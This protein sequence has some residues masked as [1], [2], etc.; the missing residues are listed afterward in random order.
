GRQTLF[1]YAANLIDLLTIQ[2]KTA[3]GNATIGQFTY[4]A[5]HRPLT[6]TD[7]AGQT[8]SYAYNTAG[9]VTSETNPLGQTT[10]YQYG[11]LGYLKKVI[12]ANGKITASFTHDIFG[13]IAT[14]TDSEG[15]TI[16][17]GYDA[18]DRV[19]EAAYPDGTT[20]QYFYDKLDLAALR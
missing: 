11:S 8:M 2:Q 6:Y 1:S 19:T 14:Y 13:R 17:F 16:G 18:A 10:S 5:Q 15:W 7:A 3:S 12:N 4:N 9:Q 20:E